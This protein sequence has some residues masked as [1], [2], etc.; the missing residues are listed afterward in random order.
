MLKITSVVPPAERFSPC[1][2]LST[3]TSAMMND[4]LTSCGDQKFLAFGHRKASSVSLSLEPTCLIMVVQRQSSNR[5][6]GVLIANS[7]T[8]VV[9]VQ[10]CLFGKFRLG[11]H[12]DN[13]VDER[14]KISSPSFAQ[15]PLF[16]LV[17]AII[18]IS[19]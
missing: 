10:A 17:S 6:E 5:D 4:L 14:S 16:S 18:G 11:K 19:D 1:T 7:C 13:D 15:D 2:L 12:V 8:I 9:I 3:S